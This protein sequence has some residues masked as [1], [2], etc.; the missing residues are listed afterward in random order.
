MN[1]YFDEARFYFTS[2]IHDVIILTGIQH[3]WQQAKDLGGKKKTQRYDMTNY[4]KYIGHFTCMSIHIGYGIRYK[5]NIWLS[6]GYKLYHLQ[7]IANQMTYQ[8]FP[9]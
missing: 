5:E 6:H 3:N 7:G 2:R 1:A 9:A 4:I 8:M